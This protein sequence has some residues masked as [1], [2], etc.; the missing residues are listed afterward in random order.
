MTA[1]CSELPESLEKALKSEKQKPQS[2]SISIGYPCIPE[3]VYG[4]R[5]WERFLRTH[6]LGWFPV[7]DLEAAAATL[8]V[9][10]RPTFNRAAID[11][12]SF[13][14][15]LD[16]GPYSQLGSSAQGI[17]S[18]VIFGQ[19]SD[20]STRNVREITL[21]CMQQHPLGINLFSMSAFKDQC[22]SLD[23]CQCWPSPLSCVSA[24]LN[25]LAYIR[26]MI[27]SQR[28][29]NSWQ[30]CLAALVAAAAA[31]GAR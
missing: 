6:S 13:C 2:Q 20:G 28:V 7:S 30:G 19:P 4:R 18:A 8:G 1:I 14:E 31:N 24:I 3:L 22:E 27:G 15:E 5:L 16:R 10:V 29:S 9:I 21:H 25:M 12:Q 17:N 11:K 23:R 26:S